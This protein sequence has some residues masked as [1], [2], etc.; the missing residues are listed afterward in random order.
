MQTNV[1]QAIK[2]RDVEVEWSA[3]VGMCGEYERRRSF[4]RETNLR[5]LSPGKNR[6]ALDVSGGFNQALLFEK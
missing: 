5:K 2:I 4:R 6:P 1:E 3:F